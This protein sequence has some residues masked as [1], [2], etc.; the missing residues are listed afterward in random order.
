MQLNLEGGG[1]GGA[2]ER[3]REED[4]KMVCWA[5][6]AGVKP[7]VPGPKGGAKKGRMVVRKP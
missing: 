6:C 1:G 2:G 7:L 3:A 4:G 5:V